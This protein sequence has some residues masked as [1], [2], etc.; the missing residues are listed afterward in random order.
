LGRVLC[1]LLPISVQTSQKGLRAAI[2]CH[3]DELSLS[4]T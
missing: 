2:I 3:F 4:L 1:T